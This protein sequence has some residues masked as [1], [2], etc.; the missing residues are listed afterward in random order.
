MDKNNRRIKVGIVDDHQLFTTSL[1][2][3]IAGFTRFEVVLEAIHGKDLQKKLMAAKVPPEIML[4]DVNMPVMD[5]A[6]VSQ[7]LKEKYPDIKLIALSMNDQEESII[8][9]FRAGCCAYLFKD[10][11][12]Q[13]LEKALDRV[14]TKGYYSPDSH[15]IDYQHMLQT[16][17]EDDPDFTRREKQFLKYC[18]T[19]LT[20]KEISE[21]M[22]ISIRTVDSY[23]ELMF[24]KLRVS[25]RTS[26]VLKALRKKI[27]KI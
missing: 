13:E 16:A 1:G 22:D 9:M 10:M 6:A 24:K 18:C 2:L 4:I 20:Y 11:A 3:L 7:W 8:R 15:P 25:T 17:L 21:K 14:Y 27:I 23:R 12:P 5:G 26:M 19:D